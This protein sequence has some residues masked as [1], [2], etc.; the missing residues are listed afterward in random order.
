MHSDN[1]Y[2]SIF[3]KIDNFT[4]IML[5]II[6]PVFDLDMSFKKFKSGNLC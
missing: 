6:M 4:F 3:D 1:I 2:S 5:T